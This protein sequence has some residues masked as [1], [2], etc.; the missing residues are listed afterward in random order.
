LP[1]LAKVPFVMNI[2]MVLWVFVTIALILIILIQKGK[3]GGLSAA[4]GGL[5]AGGLLGTKTGDFLTWV[6]ICFVVA[7]LGLAVLMVKYYKPVMPEDTG[8]SAVTTGVEDTSSP[9]GE[10]TD[11]AGGEAAQDTSAVP[12]A[13]DRSADDGKPAPDDAETTPETDT[14][15]EADTVSEADTTPPA[16]TN[17]Q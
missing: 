15:P 1:L 7:F 17:R 14:T 11:T 3:G 6:T 5:G 12:A 8:T 4:F 13:T 10:E 2:V 16:G 9:A